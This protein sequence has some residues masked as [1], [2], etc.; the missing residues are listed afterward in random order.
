MVHVYPK[1][2]FF[3]NAETGQGVWLNGMADILLPYDLKV[4]GVL[5]FI[6]F[7]VAAV[8]SNLMIVFSLAI[9][10][11]L[12]YNLPKSTSLFLVANQWKIHTN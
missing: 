10:Q 7:A 9:P 8:V 5:A 11:I 12:E 6:A 2:G 4:I 3:L 1:S